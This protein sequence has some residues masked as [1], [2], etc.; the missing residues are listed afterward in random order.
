LWRE[1]L[2]IL[3]KQIQTCTGEIT[4]D[5]RGLDL[6]SLESVRFLI[7]C[8]DQGIGISNASSYVTYWMKRE[9]MPKDDNLC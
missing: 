3:T 8:Q 2:G 1:H 9:R 4:L 5:L 7:T 6:I